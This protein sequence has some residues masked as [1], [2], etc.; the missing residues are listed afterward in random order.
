MRNIQFIALAVV[1]V[2]AGCATV[3]PAQDTDRVAELVTMLESADGAAVADQSAVPFLYNRELVARGADVAL[4]WNTL[5][6]YG[7]SFAGA[8]LAEVR[9]LSAGDVDPGTFDEQVYLDRLPEDAAL[10][11][12]QIAGIGR[13]E[14]I[15]GGELDRLPLI[16]GMR[17]P[18]R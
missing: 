8:Q 17:G 16:Y 10:A 7:F 3:P 15:L 5:G 1:V 13:M 9:P 18:L 11:V 6:E 12:V 14:L 4:L 2:I